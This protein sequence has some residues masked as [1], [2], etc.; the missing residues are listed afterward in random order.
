[1]SNYKLL[2]LTNNAVGAV[3]ADSL[4]PLGT[5]TRKIS[6]QNNCADTFSVSSSASDTVYLNTPGYYKI[7][8]VA[9]LLP[10]AASAVTVSLLA[11][12]T[13]VNSSTA[14]S[15]A[16]GYSVNIVVS[17]VIRVFPNCNS[18]S[19]NVPVSVQMQLSTTDV[20]GGN[21][22]LIIEKVY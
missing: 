18:S 9:S 6:C 2:Q 7:T 11:N 3:A 15:S 21:A 8:Y 22:N 10:G 1:M 12:G 16:I 13:S 5:V 19:N 14:E 17:F 20:T 4:I